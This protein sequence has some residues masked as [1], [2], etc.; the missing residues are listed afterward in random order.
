MKLNSKVADWKICGIAQVGGA[1]GLGAGIWWFELKSDSL[2]LREPVMFLG[3]GVGV[4]GSI[5]GASGPD[6][7]DLGNAKPAYADLTCDRAFSVGDLD[8]SA[9]RITSAGVGLAV[10]YGLVYI[11]AFNLNGSMFYSQSVGGLTVGVGA[12]AIATI[13][14]WRSMT[15]A[16]QD[17]NRAGR[18]YLTRS[19][20]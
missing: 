12:G 18:G 8:M 6:L 2:G 1:G 16:G 9:G 14:Y 3:A 11:S 20:G 5:G 7:S 10:G 15:I 13:G 4:G 17:A 19:A